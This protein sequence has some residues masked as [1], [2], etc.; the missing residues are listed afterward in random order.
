MQAAENFKTFYERSRTLQWP[1][2]LLRLALGLLAICA[3]SGQAMAG[4]TLELAWDPVVDSRVAVYEVHFGAASGQYTDHVEAILPSASLPAPA[5]GEVLYYA[6]RAC[7]AARALC[8][9]FSN[10]V[11]RAAT[12]TLSAGFRDSQESGYAP[13]TVLFTDE[14]SGDITGRHWELGDSTLVQDGT[15]VTHTYTQPGIYSVR[16]TVDGPSGSDVYERVDYV[17]VLEPLPG[18]DVRDSGSGSGSGSGDSSD[19]NRTAEDPVADAGPVLE[20][21]EI[22]VDHQW[23]WVGLK[24]S[25]DDPVVVVTAPSGNGVN[26]TTVRVA[27]VRPDGFYVRLQ[28]WGY[29]DG[30]HV[31]ERLAYLVLERGRHQLGNGAWV[32]AG[33]FD[34]DATQ[35]FEPVDFS[36]PFETAPVILAS[37]I[38]VNGTD[39]VTTRLNAIDEFGF[40]VVLQ[41]Q[42]YNAFGHAAETL[43]YVAWEPSAG[44]VDGY[45]FEVG[46]TPRVVDHR[47]HG[48]VFDT[49]FST[50]PM[51]LAHLQTMHGYDTANLRWSA[52]EEAGLGVWVAEERSAD[53]E[54][55][56]IPEV[57]GYLAVEDTLASPDGG[58]GAGINQP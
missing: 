8:S 51:L 55:L 30:W 14:S 56:H 58:E 17:Q 27:G 5:A 7:D 37:V 40:K 35:R 23:Q 46:R 16:L 52:S 6:V 42:E 22:G 54:V 50:M 29:L 18:T 1:R 28:E 24:R 11:T 39:A 53:E 9:G 31:T 45:R 2:V 20:F 15:Q 36:A 19:D 34:T 4:A 25:F 12:G 10:E 13:L 26:G 38:T 49:D 44:M 47:R 57:V 21:G 3:A 48:L 43:S 41:E 32:E 33:T